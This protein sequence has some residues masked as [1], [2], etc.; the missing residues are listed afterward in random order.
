M[1]LPKKGSLG[2]ALFLLLALLGASVSHAHAL[3]L[4]PAAIGAS[5]VGVD[6][7]SAHSADANPALLGLRKH[8]LQLSLT[9]L[10]G[11]LSNNAFS[12]SNIRSLIDSEGEVDDGDDFLKHIPDEDGAWTMR[13]DGAAGA[14]VAF[15]SV[16]VGGN[17]VLAVDAQL[18]KGILDF[19]LREPRE[20]TLYTIARSGGSVMGYGEVGGTLTVPVAPL[21]KALGVKAVHAGAGLKMLYGL[22]FAEITTEGSKGFEVVEDLVTGVLTPDGDAKLTIVSGEKGRGSAFDLGLAVEI[23]DSLYVDFAVT[24][25]GEIRWEDAHRSVYRASI[26]SSD[27]ANPEAE[28][29][30]V[31]S[32]KL[33][34]YAVDAPQTVRAGIGGNLGGAIRWAA[35]YTQQVK[36]PGEGT[37]AFGAG[38]ELSYLKFLP[39][40]L[41]MRSIS[42]SSPVYSAGFGLHVGPLTFDLATPDLGALLG[43]ESTEWAVAVSTGLRF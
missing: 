35:E 30:E 16:S 12:F 3:F 34:K 6:A 10:S 29:E 17:V 38:V 2:L 21:A 31:E 39:L 15:G 25:I 33:D 28:F 20:N 7:G 24:N 43:N 32:T 36:G 40:R 13:A 14:R 27:P 19:W 9:P 11:S 37:R 26:D 8:G 23:N 4:S 41:G 5:A 18:D 42:G 1:S 22:G